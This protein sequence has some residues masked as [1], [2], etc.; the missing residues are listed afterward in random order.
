MAVTVAFG[1]V[2]VESGAASVDAVHPTAS[3]TQTTDSGALA[4][5]ALQLRRAIDGY[6]PICHRAQRRDADKIDHA[7]GSEAVD[8]PGFA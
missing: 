7:D 2:P 8:V 4:S 1:L 3:A 5:R 6:D